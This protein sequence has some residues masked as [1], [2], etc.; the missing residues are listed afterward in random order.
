MNEY[1]NAQQENEKRID[2]GRIARALYEYTGG[3]FARA[4]RSTVQRLAQMLNYNAEQLCTD[5]QELY[6]FISDMS[7]SAYLLARITA[8]Y[9]AEVNHN[10]SSGELDFMPDEHRAGDL[11]GLIISEY[12]LRHYPDLLDGDE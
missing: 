2:R 9:N 6:R 11:L 5:V 1:Q 10:R 4:D 3:E 12:A 7:E 8:R